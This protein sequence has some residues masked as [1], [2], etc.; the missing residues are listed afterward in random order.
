MRI[1]PVVGPPHIAVGSKI[2]D[3]DVAGHGNGGVPLIYVIWVGHPQSDADCMARIDLCPLRPMFVACL[4][5]HLPS[6]SRSHHR[7]PACCNHRRSPAA[8]FVATAAHRRLPQLFAVVNHLDSP[9]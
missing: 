6:A 9:E 7:S 2:N 8:P 5:R 1:L 3:P 4:A